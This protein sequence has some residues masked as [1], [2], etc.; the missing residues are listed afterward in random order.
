MLSTDRAQF[1][2]QLAILCAGFSVPVG[3][4]SQA[5]WLGLA[6]MELA[7]FARVVAE[8]LGEGGPEKMPTVSVCWAISK[9]MR[10]VRY[11]PPEKPQ[12]QGDH[13]DIEANHHL[14][15]HIRNHPRR[16]A[17]DSTY[18]QVNGAWQ[19]VPGPLTKQYTAVVVAAKRAWAE[20][21]RVEPNPTPAIKKAAWDDCME[22]ADEQIRLLEVKAA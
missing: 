12:W 1:D 21:M 18:E 19:A 22:R 11:V 5:F 9:R 2:A 14:L 10:T 7:T 8:C 6:K 3:D 15:N 16:Y 13:W 20:D 4:R 17:P